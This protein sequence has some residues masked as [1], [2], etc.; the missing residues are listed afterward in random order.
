MPSALIVCIYIALPCSILSANA[1]VKLNPP[2]LMVCTH[3]PHHFLV[4]GTTPCIFLLAGRAI[5]ILQ[6]SLSQESHRDA[7]EYH[8]SNS[9]Q[10]KHAYNIYIHIYIYISTHIIPMASSP[11]H[12]P[13]DIGI[14]YVHS[15]RKL[16]TLNN[17]TI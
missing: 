2:T 5:V 3:S 8:I 12:P 16:I 11:V 9:E 14:Y 10:I 17:M 13:A 1:H 4:L 15:W 6:S 7:S